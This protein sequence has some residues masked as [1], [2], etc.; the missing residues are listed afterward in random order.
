MFGVPQGS[1]LGPI[2]YLL[3]TAD[4]SLLFNKH[5]VAGH[6][7]ADDSQALVHG[8][9]SSQLTLV[10]VNF[11]SDLA[12][13]MSSNRLCLNS[14]KTKL[15]WFGTRQQLAKLDIPFL[16]VTFP[17]LNFVSSVR[18]LGVL[19]NSELTL[20]DHVSGLTRSCYYHL[21]R[22]RAVRRSVSASVFKSLVHAMVSSRIDF[23]CSIYIGLPKYRLAALQSVLNSA[24]RLIA[25]TH[26]FAHIS[27]YMSEYLHWLPIAL[28]IQLRM[29]IHVCRAF[30]GQAPRYLTETICRPISASSDRPLR[31]LARSELSVPRARTSLAQHS[32]FANIGPALWNDLPHPLRT[33]LLA[34]ELSSA[35]RALK[36][37]LFPVGT[38]I[39]SA[40]EQPVL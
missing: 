16:S 12:L 14:A 28:R 34:S 1:V 15:I 7:Y 17:S 30:K 35:V 20:S 26:R 9:S 32:A 38:R 2:L 29:T 4:I 3:Y 23:C 33:A 40:S 5:C 8:P 36:S 19:L 37:F 21:R 24:A 27:L 39:E 18:N 6:L 31:S 13:W 25:R 11:S 10:L 22:L